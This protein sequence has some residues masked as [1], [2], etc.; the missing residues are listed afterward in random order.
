MPS[1]DPLQLLADYNDYLSRTAHWQQL[2]CKSRRRLNAKNIE[3]MKAMAKWCEEQGVEPRLWLYS[4]FAS[5][6]WTFAPPFKHLCSVKHLERFK[7]MHPG[8][9]Y[10][11]KVQKESNER[12]TQN[13][14]NFDPN[15]DLSGTAEQLKRYYL[16]AGYPATCMA[17]VTH[18]LGFH[19]KSSVCARC[20]VAEACARALQARVTFDIMALRRGE[21]SAEDARAQAAL[22]HGNRS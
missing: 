4:L 10:A 21:L 11:N 8:T 20:P 13:A 9:F 3:A 12:V 16:D 1:A 7:Q 6:H 18:T 22:S 14:D 5:R 2:P 15:R 19:P 17:E